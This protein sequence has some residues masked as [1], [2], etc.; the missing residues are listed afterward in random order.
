MSRYSLDSSQCLIVLKSTARYDRRL[1]IL[2]RH[3]RNLLFR[4]SLHIAQPRYVGFL[5]HDTF[6][7]GFMETDK[8]PSETAADSGKWSLKSIA[9]LMVQIW[10]GNTY[11]SFAQAESFHPLF[12]PILMTMFAALS[13]TLLLTSM[14]F[15]FESDR[16]LTVRPVLISILSNTFARIDAVCT[17]HLSRASPDANCAYRMPNKNISSSF[18]SR[19]LR[20]KD[21]YSDF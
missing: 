6:P 17:T 15:A 21:C 2:H 10:F 4:A 16:K 1:R 3:R 13:S 12:G 5:S 19:R 9:W 11:L 8:L 7:L 14:F 18:R 20:G